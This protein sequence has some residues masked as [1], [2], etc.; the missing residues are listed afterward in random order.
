MIDKKR[1]DALHGEMIDI[2]MEMI[3]KIEVLIEASWDSNRL[4]VQI[5][6]LQKARDR[7]MDELYGNE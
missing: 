2:E 1:E 6:S 7:L 5:E 3:H 4:K